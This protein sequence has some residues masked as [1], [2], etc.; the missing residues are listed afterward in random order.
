M[1]AQASQEA[2]CGSARWGAAQQLGSN[3]TKLDLDASSLRSFAAPAFC[4]GGALA[5]ESPVGVERVV[6]ACFYPSTHLPGQYK[7]S[8]T[9]RLQILLGADA[10]QR[11][12]L[13]LGQTMHET[14]DMATSA[15][16]ANDVL[17]QA[18]K[19]TMRAQ[20]VVPADSIQVSEAATV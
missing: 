5:A 19:Q 2:G 10:C 9:A 14:R 17:G 15:L 1:R 11:K 13:A 8:L 6:W 20:V 7:A 18:A 12:T 3:N 4:W 16:K